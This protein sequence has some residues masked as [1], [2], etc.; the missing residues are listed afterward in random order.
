VGRGNAPAVKRGVVGEDAA[1]VDGGEAC[2]TAF[3]GRPT[4]G[5]S[6]PDGLAVADRNV[7]GEAGGES[8]HASF[9]A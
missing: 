3:T 7:E 9:S 5:S 6:M 2:R 8:K 4:F 1:A